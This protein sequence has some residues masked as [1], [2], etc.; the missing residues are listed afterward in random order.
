MNGRKP[1]EGICTESQ[2]LALI[3]NIDKTKDVEWSEYVVDG[4]EL[5]YPMWKAVAASEGDTYEDFIK[6]FDAAKKKTSSKDVVVTDDEKVGSVEPEDD[7]D[8]QTEVDVFTESASPLI[9]NGEDLVS[10]VRRLMGNNHV[11]S[12]NSGV[13]KP[14]LD[15]MPTKSTK[16]VT[17]VD[18][19]KENKV[20]ADV[21]KKATKAGVGVV[22]ADDAFVAQ[23]KVDVTDGEG[24]KK[25][26][27]QLS[28]MT[29]VVKP[30]AVGFKGSAKPDIKV[31]AT[32]TTI[33]IK[34]APKDANP[35]VGMIKPD[36]DIKPNPKPITFKDAIKNK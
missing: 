18:A 28:D 1:Y 2:M 31:D 14:K 24:L 29:G 35:K 15:G 13:V 12:D 20:E 33:E 19:T 11:V 32:K 22:K 30:N 27:A 25:G 6:Y 4:E 10:K 34:D 9:F 36:S 17:E 16:Q 5:S 3:E 21:A 7:F 8:D 26:P 23:T